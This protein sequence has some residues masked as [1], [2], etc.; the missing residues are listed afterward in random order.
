M[1]GNTI[2]AI[3]MLAVVSTV[4][5]GC[6]T[7]SSVGVKNDLADA[8][9]AMEQGDYGKAEQAYAMAA[10]A[11]PSAKNYAMAATAAYRADDLQNAE[12]YVN[13][14]LR[15]DGNST[16][17][18]RL[19]AYRTLVLLRQG[20]QQEGMQAL[21]DYYQKYKNY[22]PM[23]DYARA[24]RMA[25]MGPPE[26]PR[27]ERLLEGNVR[28]YESDVAQYESEGT[29]YFAEKYGPPAVFGTER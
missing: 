16:S 15:I 22:Y 25:S 7:S 24:Q 18:M 27:L 11:D 19:L 23:P 20:R 6:S 9:T 10:Q 4:F 12:R 26:L 14:G 2:R 13:E 5:L 17:Y 29:G 1:M 21:N 28:Q 3:I 8:R